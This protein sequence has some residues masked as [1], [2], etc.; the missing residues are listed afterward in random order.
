M[1][2][3]PL[4]AWILP[5]TLPGSALSPPKRR[6]REKAATVR[7]LSPLRLPA[8]RAAQKQKAR[9]RGTPHTRI[10]TDIRVYTVQVRFT[11]Y[12]ALQITPAGLTANNHPSSVGRDFFSN[13]FPRMGKCVILNLKF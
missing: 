1:D 2:R 12:L 5:G 3:T 6:V 4:R 8:G 13:P 9:V 10:S 7:R 11:T